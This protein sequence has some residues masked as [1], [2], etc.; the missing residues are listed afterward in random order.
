MSCWSREISDSVMNDVVDDIESPESAL[1]IRGFLSSIGGQDVVSSSGGVGDRRCLG[2][3]VRRRR[4]VATVF[5]KY[6]LR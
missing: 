1:L 3:M 2:A 6:F 4:R 5:F